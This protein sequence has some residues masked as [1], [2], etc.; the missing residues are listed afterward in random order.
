MIK[1]NNIQANKLIGIYNNI[2]ALDIT[3]IEDDF[4]VMETD[5]EILNENYGIAKRYIKSIKPQLI[6]INVVTQETIKIKA[7][8]ISP[9]R[10]TDYEG[11]HITKEL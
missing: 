6:D 7:A 10:K 3:K 8:L 2:W 1:L 4:W 9:N 11:R 5:P